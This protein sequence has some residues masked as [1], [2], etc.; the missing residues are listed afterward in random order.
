M[1]KDNWIL[2]VFVLAF[3]LSFLFATVSNLLSNINVVLMVIILLVVIFVGILFDM[4]GVAVLSANEASFHA[5][6]SNKIYGAKKAVELVKNANKTSTV[7]NDVIGD[8]CGIISGALA[9][10]LVVVLW[11]SNPFFSILITAMVSSLTVGGKAI[12]KKLG[13]RYADDII[14]KVAIIISK[15][16]LK[17]N[18]K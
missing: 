13:I 4:V 17:R 2:M 3:I 11:Q 10:S 6:A 8:I 16:D 15:F 9:A 7:C 1:K 14:F 18:R 12:G 5:K